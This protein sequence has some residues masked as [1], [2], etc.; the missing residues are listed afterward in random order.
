MLR[1][2]E[3]ALRLRQRLSVQISGH[4]CFKVSP[5]A[6][7]NADGVDLG[8]R[9]MERREIHSSIYLGQLDES[10]QSGDVKVCVVGS[11]PAG[12][13]AVDKVLKRFPGSEVDI[14]ERLPC[15]YGLVR[16]GVAPDH[17]ETKNVIHHFE[18]IANHP[19]VMFWGNTT[20]GGHTLSLEELREMYDA[21]I[22]AC[23]AEGGRR[24]D[25][26]GSQL[27]GIYSARDFVNWYNGYPDEMPLVIDLQ[28]VASVCIAGMGNVALDCA[29]ILLRDPESLRKT[30]ISSHAFDALKSSSVREVHLLARRGPAQAACTP[31]E[32]R[33]LLG[34]DG[35]GLQ[36]HP[37]G[38]LKLGKL[39]EDEIKG[40]RIK[41][42]VIEVLTKH[43][44]SG[45]LE[46]PSA[47]SLHLH[48]LSSPVRYLGESESLQRVDI[49]RNS[50]VP[51]EDR[52][53]QRAI[54]TGECKTI[55]AQLA[56][57]SV[58]YKGA[59]I[60]GVPFDERTATIPNSLGQ[61]V[62]E[63]QER[64][65]GLFVCGWLK[66]G[67]SGII[68]TNLVDAEQTIDTMVRSKNEWSSAGKEYRKPGR[69]SL[70]IILRD[71]G[72]NPVDMHGWKRIDDEEIS[73]GGSKGK[74]REKI[75]SVKDMLSIATA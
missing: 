40:S 4:S 68:G 26:P 43:S 42:R 66:R 55:S 57:E 33:E 13:Y 28:T 22:L 29:R 61:V 9:L 21:V 6:Y 60:P 19:N 27:K 2:L 24:L 56:I 34:I 39:C 75:L 32:L 67:P 53:Q 14:V 46:E 70:K 71:R 35:V 12:F 49:E 38:A 73:R 20:V 37:P 8:G 1:R 36:I 17:P 44:T 54:G 59:P 16:S 45:Q 58:G 3:R 51:M 5:T 47:K 74:L 63:S 69:Q 15:P 64:Y 41:R 31:K 72:H 52:S 50:L 18:T 10:G 7:V 48:F 65:P 25:L 30:D 11:G 62:D 23:G